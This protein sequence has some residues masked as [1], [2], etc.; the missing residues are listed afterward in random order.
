MTGKQSKRHDARI[1]VDLERNMHAR[2]VDPSIPDL[3]RDPDDHATEW[4]QKMHNAVKRLG[5]DP[6]REHMFW[7]F[8]LNSSDPAMRRFH[9]TAF[10]AFR[11]LTGTTF[12]ALTETPRLQTT[13][14]SAA[15]YGKA[16]Y[17]K[18]QLQMAWYATAEAGSG[19]PGV[20]LSPSSAAEA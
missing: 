15:L 1:T 20:L 19:I 5:D 17:D 2:L 10:R 16:E 8:V 4:A 7:H 6:N 18:A 3:S 13:L 14:G 11:E 9:E 12:L